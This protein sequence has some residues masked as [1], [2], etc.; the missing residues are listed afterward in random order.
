MNEANTHSS[1]LW[2]V[3]Y[4]FNVVLYIIESQD[5]HSGKTYATLLT[6]EQSRTSV[7]DLVYKTLYTLDT[8]YDAVPERYKNE[9]VA[10][11][12]RVS[13]RCINEPRV[14]IEVTQG[15]GT[16]ITP[17]RHALYDYADISFWSGDPR[18]FA[19]TADFLSNL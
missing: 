6:H 9:L 3:T 16:L 19:G 4:T 12:V 5:R 8:M 14:Y 2:K 13:L 17:H 10:P 7:G 15:D 18:L 1:T 11:L